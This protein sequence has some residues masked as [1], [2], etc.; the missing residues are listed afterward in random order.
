MKIKYTI[1]AGC[2][3]MMGMAS[4]EMKDEILG[5]KTESEA[6]GVMN[7]N[8]SVNTKTNDV[9]TKA[10][11]TQDGGEVNVPAVSASGYTVEISKGEDVVKTL[12]YDPQR[13]DIELPVG[14]YSLYAHAQ[15]DPKETEAYY[16]GRNTV[17][18]E[19]DKSVNVS[20]VCK[21]MNTKIQLSY[22]ATMQ[23]AFKSWEVTVTAGSKSKVF[24][25]DGSAFAQPDPIFWMMNEGTSEVRVSFKGVNQKGKLVIDNRV[26]TKPNA[27]DNKNWIGGDALAVNIKAKEIVEEIPDGVNG[28]EITAKVQWDGISDSVDVTVEEDGG[29]QP[30]PGPNPE[31]EQPGTPNAIKVSI[32]Q[33]TYTLPDDLGKKEDAIAAIISEKGLKSLK[34]I[35]EPGN[36][37]FESV[38]LDKQIID[39]GVDFS[40]GVELVDQPKNSPVMTLIGLIAPKLDPPT[41]GAT[42]YNF[43]LGEFFDAV[44][45]YG[46]TKKTNGHVFKISIEDKEGNINSDNVLSIIIKEQ[47]Q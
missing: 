26:I 43:P 19:K 32:P 12:I 23:A 1:L 40:K 46:A 27:A 42:S 5:N 45:I 9:L 22:D 18:I 28:I 39:K 3:L 10:D 36:E 21:M 44:S 11:G 15:G 35:I 17:K 34:V 47:G 4:C 20:V 8:V 6:M 13:T 24:S 41:S 31:P 25:Y 30:E 29:E 37:G 2:L 33:F 14:D 16:G 7:L 38:I